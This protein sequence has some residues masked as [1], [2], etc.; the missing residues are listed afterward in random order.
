VDCRQRYTDKQHDCEI[1]DFLSAAGFDL[2]GLSNDVEATLYVGSSRPDA[3]TIATSENELRSYSWNIAKPNWIS[4]LRNHELDDSSPTTCCQNQTYCLKVVE[5]A[6]SIIVCVDCSGKKCMFSPITTQLCLNL[7]IDCGNNSNT[8]TGLLNV[9]LYWNRGADGRGHV[10]TIRGQGGV[11]GCPA[12]GRNTFSAPELAPPAERETSAEEIAAMT[13][14]EIIDHERTE[15]HKEKRNFASNTGRYTVIL[16]NYSVEVAEYTVKYSQD[17]NC[18]I[19]ETICRGGNYLT[20][21]CMNTTCVGSAINEQTGKNGGGIPSD[22]IWVTLT[23]GQGK[24]I[25]GPRGRWTMN[26]TLCQWERPSFINATFQKVGNQNF[27]FPVIRSD[28]QG[29]RVEEGLLLPPA[30]SWPEVRAHP[31]VWI[32]FECFLT[33]SYCKEI[34]PN[35]TFALWEVVSV[36]GKP[37]TPDYVLFKFTADP[38][39]P[40]RDDPGVQGVFRQVPA[41]SVAWGAGLENQSSTWVPG[42]NYFCQVADPNF[43]FYL[44]WGAFAF[45]NFPYEIPSSLANSPSLGVVFSQFSCSALTTPHPTMPIESMNLCRGCQLRWVANGADVNLVPLTDAGLEQIGSANLLKQC[46]FAWV[47]PGS[48]WLLDKP[49]GLIFLTPFT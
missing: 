7:G 43:S 24:Q 11:N 19:P 29:V 22:N 39:G 35:Q 26:S 13:E 42:Y 5:G 47:P 8:I 15:M 40:N 36:R 12:A 17:I 25:R 28:D 33:S 18:D 49:L 46:R 1:C 44:N 16:G 37:S 9:N 21:Q 14:E 34:L 23:D 20:C 2:S 4:V 6:A 45:P 48:D 32:Q 3:T 41:D 27:C 10:R 31:Q 38:Y 30:Q